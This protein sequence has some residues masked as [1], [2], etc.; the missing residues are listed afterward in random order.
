MAKYLVVI[1]A[2]LVIVV[3]MLFFAIYPYFVQSAPT[4]YEFYMFFFMFLI[5]ILVIVSAYASATAKKP[6]S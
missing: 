5:L 1:W 2:I 6:E 3:L 4:G